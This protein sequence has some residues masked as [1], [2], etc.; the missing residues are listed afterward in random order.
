MTTE[1][2]V[3]CGEAR[4]TIRLASDGLELIDHPDAES[5]LILAALGGDKPNC[6]RIV[7]AWQRR[8]ADIDLLMILPRSDDDQIRVSWGDVEVARSPV[9]TSVAMSGPPGP[10]VPAG[11]PA[12]APAHIRQM[13]AT[14]KETYA[15]QLD[16]LTV[17]ALGHEFQKRLVG[18]IVASVED[19]PPGE[20]SPAL[21]A[22]LAGR[23]GPA[24]ARWLDVNADDVTVA[25]YRGS[26]WGSLFASDDAVWVALPVSWLAEVWAPGLELVDGR[27]VVGVGSAGMVAVGAPGSET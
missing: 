8:A 14:L 22:A 27:F 25:V 10:P 11:L 12:G 20:A 2:T 9:R 21:A 19:A 17:L 3:P 13:Q 23:A 6:I 26:G 24:I 5:E 7:E 15:R 1:T 18:T 4:H 16:I